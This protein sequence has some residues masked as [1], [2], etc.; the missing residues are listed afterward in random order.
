MKTSK[1]IFGTLATF[2]LVGCSLSLKTLS[3]S[4]FKLECNKVEEK[5]NSY[6]NQNPYV[7]FKLTLI[8]ENEGSGTVT[9]KE[10]GSGRVDP[11][12]HQ[13]T[14]IAESRPG[15]FDEFSLVAIFASMPAMALLEEQPEGLSKF[16]VTLNGYKATG[17]EKNVVEWN[18]NGMLT[19]YK[20][21]DEGD[22]TEL[23][24]SWSL[25]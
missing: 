7:S 1:I 13:L 3:W 16:S 11:T 22:F 2:A 17:G 10:D 8:E 5:F 12:T 4:E 23:S 14:M 19:S 18:K 9:T 25:K 21:G 15:L 6:M 24:V 20:M